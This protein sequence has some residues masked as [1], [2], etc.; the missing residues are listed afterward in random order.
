VGNSTALVN[1]LTIKGLTINV[2]DVEIAC[3]APAW[4]HA[5]PATLQVFFLRILV[6]FLRILDAVGLFSSYTTDVDGQRFDHERLGR[7]DR[8][9]GPRVAARVPG[10][11]AGLFSSYTKVYSVIYDSESVPD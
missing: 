4:P 7:G 10:D 11:A 3:L 8:V 1:G 2:S 9:P 6:F 5:S